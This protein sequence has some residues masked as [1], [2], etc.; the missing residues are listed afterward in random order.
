M[1]EVTFI[2]KLSKNYS[3]ECGEKICLY[4]ENRLGGEPET[5]RNS[6]YFRNRGRGK[7][8]G[9]RAVSKDRAETDENGEVEGR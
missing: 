3:R 5:E 7:Q 6:A 1:E 9:R 8:C 4:G 2:G